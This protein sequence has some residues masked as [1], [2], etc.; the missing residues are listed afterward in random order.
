MDEVVKLH[1]LGPQLTPPGALWSLGAVSLLRASS[2]KWDNDCIY[3][4]AC[5]DY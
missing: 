3:L 4:L 5:G 2:E 1:G